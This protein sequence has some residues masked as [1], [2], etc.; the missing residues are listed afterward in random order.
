MGEIV[1]AAL[2]RFVRLDDAE[3]LREPLLGQL[4]RQGVRG[5]LLLANEG[6]NG[7]IAGPRAGIDAVLAWLKR[8]PR[9][10]ALTHKESACEAMP[11]RRT[12]VRIKKEIVTMGVAGLDPEHAAGAYVKPAD[13]NALVDDPAVTLIDTRN[14][15]E[16]ELGTFEGAV[17]PCTA[18]FREFPEY[19]RTHLDP[20][21]NKKVAMFCTGGIRCEK[22][23][24]YLKQLGFEQVYH[25]EGG[26]LKYLEQVPAEQSR[27]RGECFVFDERVS[28]GHGLT[29]GA[30]RLCYACR[31]PVSETDRLSERFIKGVS[32]PRCYDKVDADRRA[33]FEQRQKQVELASQRG[34][35]H[36]GDDARR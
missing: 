23:T 11:F 35:T 28:V 3:Q 32:C 36:I 18:S 8:D 14:D 4:R 31:M 19:A 34:E 27:W 33:R 1:V 16:V 9:L 13:W 10:A 2:Y 7:T 21:T 12:K 22:A 20:T 26:V 15:Y 29:P 17:D 5:T 6:I 25:L 24:A 30:Y